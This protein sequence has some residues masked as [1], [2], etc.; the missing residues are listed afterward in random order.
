MEIKNRILHSAAALFMRNGIKSVSM[1]DIAARLAMSK[2]TLY[3]WFENKDQIVVG[4]MQQHLT[5]EEGDCCQIAEGA[6]NALDELFKLMDWG[7]QMMADLHPSIFYDLQ[8]YYPQAWQLWLVHKE[9]FIL[10]RIIDN[11]RRGMTEG[12]YRADLDV[13]VLARLR[14]NQIDLALNP[15]VFP[16]RQFNPQKVDLI[17]LE[18]FMLGVA[19]LKGHKLINRFRHVTEEE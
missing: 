3:K 9:Q 10:H 19:T 2:K 15:N 14:L 6:E 17:C 1:D 12:L 8:K 16:T 11:L 18:H 4:V 7:Q 13:D 5:E